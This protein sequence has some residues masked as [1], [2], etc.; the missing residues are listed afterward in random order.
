MGKTCGC[1]KSETA[2]SM[3]GRPVP[4]P[5]TR[6]RSKSL[7]L[8]SSATPPSSMHSELYGLQLE[9]PETS[10]T[11]SPKAADIVTTNINCDETSSDAEDENDDCVPITKNAMSNILD[12]PKSPF[13][14]MSTDRLHQLSDSVLEHSPNLVNDTNTL[15]PTISPGIE[16]MD[17]TRLT[18]MATETLDEIRLEMQ[19]SVSELVPLKGWLMK[20]QSAPPFSWQRR[21]VTVKGGYL[22]WSDR[23]IIIKHGVTA[24][25]RQRWNK[26]IRVGSISSVNVYDS[27]KQ[28]KF[29][30]NVRGVD[31]AYLFKAVS[32]NHRDEWIK[33]LKEHIEFANHASVYA[34]RRKPNR[35]QNK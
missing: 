18:K 19:T 6:T 10:R 9:E 2:P 24:E 25:E 1:E 16:A 11:P 22:L 30:V 26:C 29:C 15:M 8:S 14:K 34:E 17:T 23:Q 35:S 32:K 28:R 27:T 7:S 3:E 20:K 21:W 13:A 12:S 31:R 33:V 4:A 5:R